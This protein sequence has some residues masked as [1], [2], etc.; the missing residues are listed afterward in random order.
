MEGQTQA[1]LPEP[2][3]HFD[4]MHACRVN[5]RLWCYG[6][7]FFEAGVAPEWEDPQNAGGVDL[8]CRRAFDRAQLSAAWRTVVLLLAHGA[9]EEA[10]GARVTYKRDRRGVV[11]K[12]EVWC[13]AAADGAPVA[14]R[15][16][17]RVGF[18]FV[19]TPRRVTR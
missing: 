13:R 10:T 14:A 1:L 19:V 8:V 6:L 4:G 5:G 7:C 17:E 16:L 12:L 3:A 11:H 2:G 9:L 15:L 18:E